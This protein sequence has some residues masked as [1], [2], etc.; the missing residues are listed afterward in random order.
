MYIHVERLHNPGKE[1]RV[2]RV[3]EITLERLLQ[4]SSAVCKK[5]KS[6]VLCTCNPITQGAETG[7]LPI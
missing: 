6:V 5:A 3:L 4:L 7:G 1:H 2:L